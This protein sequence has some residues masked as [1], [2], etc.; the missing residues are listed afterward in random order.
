MRDGVRTY[1]DGNFLKSIMFSIFFRIKNR[2]KPRQIIVEYDLHWTTTF[3]ISFSGS[4]PQKLRQLIVE[5]YLHWTITFEISF[6]GGSDKNYGS[7]LYNTTPT[8]PPRL[9]Y[10]FQV[11][12]TQ[13]TT[14]YCRILPTQWTPT[15]KDYGLYLCRS[16]L[17]RI[18]VQQE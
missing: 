2:P 15:F 16:I 14:A 12:K 9:R 10:L 6:S 7:L 13:T 11:V 8:G 1:K 4:S 18:L 5:Y 17:R 3:E